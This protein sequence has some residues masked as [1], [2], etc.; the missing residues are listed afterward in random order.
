M[1]DLERTKLIAY[2]IGLV[3]IAIAAII[4]VV[5]AIRRRKEI[6]AGAPVYP[7]RWAAIF[8]FYCVGEFAGE[9]SILNG[10]AASEWILTAVALLVFLPLGIISLDRYARQAWFAGNPTGTWNG[11]TTH[12]IDRRRWAWKS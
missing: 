1:T 4:G 8:W 5:A 10:I 3:P 12:D 7:G 11:L 6:P 9:I 2:A